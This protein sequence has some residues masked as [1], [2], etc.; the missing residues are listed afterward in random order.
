MLELDF[1]IGGRREPGAANGASAR[2]IM[3][4]EK[5]GDIT[6]RSCRRPRRERDVRVA[7]DGLAAVTHITPS[8]P[9]TRSDPALIAES[10]NGLHLI[11]W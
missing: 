6:L 5:V 1:A 11:C 8:S 10:I 2:V 9:L 4:V 7:N 3:L